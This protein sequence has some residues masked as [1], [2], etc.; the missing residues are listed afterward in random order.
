MASQ[1]PEVRRAPLGLDRWGIEAGLAGI[2]VRDVVE[3]PDGFVWIATSGGLSRFDGRSFVDL[4]AATTPSLPTNSITALAP[5]AD[6]KLWVGLEHGGVRSLRAG[7]IGPDPRLA[8]LPTDLSVRDPLEDR[9]GVL[10]VATTT[11][12]WRVGGDGTG[13]VAPS[14]SPEDARSIAGRSIE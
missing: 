13:R 3:G 5:G 10:W 14:R 12:R 6:G 2:G 7:A 8:A 11:G 4:T 1:A 9:S